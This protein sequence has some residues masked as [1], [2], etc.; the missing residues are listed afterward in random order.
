M[1]FAGKAVADGDVF[2][3]VTNSF[4]AAGGDN[5][6]TFAQGGRVTDTGQS[7]LV[8]TV[9]YFE[10]HPVVEPAPLGRAI[11]AADIPDG[12]NGSGDGGTV[13]P[14]DG[15]VV[16]GDGTVFPGAGNGGSDGGSGTTTGDGTTD[17]NLPGNLATTGATLTMAGVGLLLALLGGLL[18][19]IRRRKTAPMAADS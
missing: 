4:L 19:V 1:E 15:T 3:V 13:V 7:D 14:G 11:L 6:T 8:A 17:A 16:P 10:A 18:V 9:Q 12:G 2:R 5:F